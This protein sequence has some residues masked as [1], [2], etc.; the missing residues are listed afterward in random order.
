MTAP[1]KIEIWSDISCSWCYIGKRK[2][3][4]GIAIFSQG[5]SGVKVQVEYRSF[6]LAPDMPVDFE[7]SSIDYL[8]DGKG[9]SAVQVEQGLEEITRIAASVGLEYRFA[10]VK[11]T[12]TMKAHQLLHYA[13]ARGLQAATKERL[14]KAYFA[15]GKHLGRLD[16]LADLAAEIGLE[17]DDVVRSLA[18]D[19]YLP[20]VHADRQLA[21]AHNV[22]GVPF[23]LLDGKHAV[24]G[25]QDAATFVR[26]LEQVARNRTAT[27][28]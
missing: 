7:G 6:Q 13:G 2:L 18:N 17:R 10:I 14:L 21:A 5:N 23:F 25:A 27:G 1:I 20:A 8:S 19:E 24:S 4:D 22:R 12:N 3:D 26:V 15:E 11:P 9:V 16:D 28:A